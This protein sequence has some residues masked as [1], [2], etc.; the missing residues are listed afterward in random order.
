MYLSGYIERLGTGT[1]DMV[2]R[3]K[4]AGLREPDFLQ[5]EDFRVIIYRTSTREVTPQVK[6]VVLM[7]RGEKSR[8]ELQETLGLKD[9]EN[10]RKAYIKEAL[11]LG[12]I[13]MTMSDKGEARTKNTDSQR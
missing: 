1:S 7:I 10:F 12:M 6:Q 2:A 5:L 9:R 4:I 11:K 3:A 8:E 13:E